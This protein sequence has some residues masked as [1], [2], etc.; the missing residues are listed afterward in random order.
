MTYRIHVP[1]D[2]PGSGGLLPNGSTLCRIVASIIALVILL[3]PAARALAQNEHVLP[4]FISD[5]HQSLQGFVRII[6]RSD[7]AGTV[8]VHAV[9]DDGTRHGPIDV[10]IGANAAR[11]FNSSDLE[12]GNLDKGLSG[13][14][15]SGRG[16]W[17]L[18]LDTDLD[19]EPLAYSRPLEDGFLTSVHE[20]TENAAM[21]WHV[22]IFNPGSNTAQQSW[23][24]IVNTSG[25]DTEV[26]IDGLDD[27][28]VAPPGGTVRF[29]LPAD[30]ARML[31]AQALEQGYSQSVSDFEF[32]GSFG[33]GTGKWQLFVSAGRPIQVMSLLFSETRNLTNLS[34]VI[35]G[36]TAGVSAVGSQEIQSLARR[37]SDAR[38]DDGAEPPPLV[39]F[40]A[41]ASAKSTS[42]TSAKAAA[43]LKSIQ[44][45]PAASGVRI[46]RSA[47][48]AVVAAGALSLEL[49]PAPA[50]AAGASTAIAF[51]GID[52]DHGEEGL[53]SLYARDEDTDSE[54]ALVIQ[55]LDVLGSIRLSDDVYKVLP[56][57]DGLTAVYLHDAS[58]LRRHPEGWEELMHPQVTD[59]PPR[60]AP[61]RTPATFTT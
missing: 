5:S 44:S 43:V 29:T 35:R 24:R 55:G 16:N 27:L 7:R 14:V 30:A 8:R 36:D 56:L 32:D 11:H 47:P 53:T 4:L 33:D 59:S 3:A 58:Q 15:G 45:N 50:A 19:I 52:V 26:V 21:R 51:T 34:G 10:S 25:I 12:D 1:G 18:E 46:G 13:G 60:G 41:Y 9:D 40:S 31:S 37:N 61:M 6:N 54:V 57:G 23:L 22:A 42:G 28:A 39:V 2:L 38:R 48:A 17:R 49:P 20:V